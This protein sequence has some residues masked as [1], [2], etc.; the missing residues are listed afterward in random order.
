[1]ELFTLGVSAVVFCGEVMT[2]YITEEKMQFKRY[3]LHILATV[4]VLAGIVFVLSRSHTLIA[5]EP[6]RNVDANIS[7]NYTWKQ[8]V[9]GGGGWVTGLAVHPTTP[10]LVYG[11][12][13]VGGVFKW[14][15]TTRSWTQ[16]LKASTVYSASLG[17]GDYNVESL[18]LS[19]SNDQVLYIAVD[20]NGG[21]ILKSTDQGA[22]WTEPS[23][24]RWYIEGNGDYRMNGERLAVDPVNPDVV[25]FGSRKEGLWKT[26]DGGANWTLVPTDTIPVGTVPSGRTPP[27]VRWVLFDST[28]GT[29]P[30][31]LTR[32]IYVGVSGYGVYR[33]DDAGLTW[34][35][36]Y[37][38][39]TSPASPFSVPVTAKMGGGYL[40][41]LLEGWFRKYDPVTDTWTPIR[42]VGEWG[43]ITI[44]PKDPNLMFVSDDH[45]SS[46]HLW[47]ST[48]GGAT[49]S[50]ALD[51]DINP[52]NCDPEWICNTNV[53]DWMGI[54]DW[55]FDP[56]QSD[57][58]WL[59]EGMGM[60][61]M[62]G[63][64]NNTIT[65]HFISR[66]IEEM[67]PA[68]IVAPPGGVPVVTVMD[69]Q[70]FY[71]PDPDAYPTRTLVDGQF[72]TGAS[73][74][75]AGRAPNNLAV[76][77]SRTHIWPWTGTA[78][79]SNDGGKTWRY[80]PTLPDADK[81]G[82]IAIS[83][84]NPNNIVWLPSTHEPGDVGPVPYVTFDRGVTW[85][86]STGVDPTLSLHELVWWVNKRAL[87]ADKVLDGVFYLIAG[88]TTPGDTTEGTFYVSE[89]GGLTWTP[90]PYAPPCSGTAATDCHV[91]GQL[92]AVPGYAG[93]V[94]ASTVKT[95]LWYT[96]DG[97][98]TPWHQVAGVERAQTFG[99]GKALPG[100]DYPAIYLYGIV[101]G[102][103]GYWRSGDMGATWDLIAVYPNDN[104][105]E[106]R[107]I[108]GDMNIA[109]RV[110]IGTGGTSFI[111]GDDTTIPPTAPAA[112]NLIEAVPGDGRVSLRWGEVI[113]ATGYKVTYGLTVTQFI[114]PT[115]VFTQ[116]TYTVTGLTNNVPYYFAVLA[117]NAQ[118]DGPLSNA[119]RAIPSQY[120]PAAPYLYPPVA[121]DRTLSLQWEKV[122]GAQGYT[123]HYG[124][125]GQY[126][127]SLDVGDSDTAV[128]TELRNGAIYN[129][130]V[131]GY[132]VNGVGDPSNEQL[133][134]PNGPMPPQ[135]TADYF[136]ATLTVDGV[137]D[138]GFWNLGIPITKTVTGI[139]TATGT[140][141]VAWN[142]TYFVVGVKVYDDN[143]QND[144]VNP[145]E[146]DSVEVYFDGDDSKGS[147]YDAYDRQIVKG[148]NDDGVWHSAD[149]PG[150]LHAWA[151]ITNTEGMTIGYAVEIAIPWEGLELTPANNYQV[152]FDVGYNDDVDGDGREGQNVA[153]GIRDN[154]SD[155]RYFADVTLV[156][157]PAG[158]FMAPQSPNYEKRYIY[159][160][161]PVAPFG[162]GYLWNNVGS[163]DLYYTGNVYA[164]RYA[165]SVTLPA[166]WGDG[167]GMWSIPPGV[168]TAGMTHLTMWVHGGQVDQ[169]I[170][171]NVCSSEGQCG[172]VGWPW[173]NVPANT[174][175]RVEIPLTALT[176][177]P[178]YI[179]TINFAHAGD[180]NAT[181]YLDEIALEAQVATLTVGRAGT[182]EGTVT[183]Q[184]TAM[185][186]GQEINC[187]EVCE[188]DY[189][190]GAVVQLT[191]VT[192][193][194]TTFTGWRGACSG[195]NPVCVLTMDKSKETTASFSLNRVTVQ[196]GGDGAGTVTSDP[197]GVDCGT[198]CEAT[199]AA[200]TPLTLTT[201]TTD[202]FAGWRGGWCS[203][204]DACR[205][206]L[207]R[208][209][210]ARAIFEKLVEA[211]VADFIAS[212][213]SGPAPL[214]VHFTGI[215]TGVVTSYAWT[216]GDGATSEE[217]NPTHTYTTPGTYTVTLTVTGPG[218]SDTETKA[219]YITVTG[220]RIYLPLVLRNAP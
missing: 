117:Y 153:F 135:I 214:E 203:G 16:L 130:L 185:I 46:G 187:G 9:I 64:M 72:F 211:P 166:W 31:P 219:D 58:I 18:A 149:I 122:P 156:G 191:A 74:D 184:G 158:R 201:H 62:T 7:G 107:T 189:P 75:Y 188:A 109:G 157:K 128:L 96:T 127:Q 133:A 120:P 212:P 138:E 28:G 92:R 140:A 137:L 51:L 162:G 119:L 150:L 160:D 29:L 45:L 68:D 66:G 112:P 200:S 39:T 205:L 27:G 4:T 13:D 91:W 94:W 48:D 215:V 60:W 179:H 196:V 44:D 101:N 61:Q 129:V 209:I 36:I 25:Y 1:V 15:P 141:D 67:V 210:Y 190:P 134:S 167:F 10:D 132:N 85:Q 173:I 183:S 165:I 169:V 176:N 65:M 2:L 175:T 218:G 19:A 182:G 24:Q 186:P 103:E 56:F 102:Q 106:N 73:L 216:F 123:V 69:R 49:W 118:G 82:N 147:V 93:H 139:V 80:F 6:G 174:W 110:Y 168:S 88:H 84:A 53:G 26:T 14:N 146:D 204:T 97:G 5:R 206:T 170:W 164:G 43:A 83:A 108:N 155:T 79:Y 100:Q 207:D 52:A 35:R 142:D 20:G 115:D 159:R 143:L 99:F 78:A 197:P 77:L 192:G 30:G 181:F 76:T 38:I 131:V 114:T 17:N 161:G 177:I 148:W 42:N 86:Q 40:Y 121:G 32:R 208:W 125:A 202:I 111:Y 50:A 81:A 113:G 8:L 87:E 71:K 95:G 213:T 59:S 154:W 199:F 12:T 144:S 23:S 41:A 198:A 195:L 163:Y 47:R 70:G 145:W 180:F 217:Q 220:Y 124:R 3:F 34:R 136:T 37:T 104:Y 98:Q 116:T 90:A 194:N 11:R 22:T 89:D 33:T 178:P 151:A 193:A 105:D 63:L 152:G 126:V 57:L 21:R 54:G 172:E 171:L 55:H